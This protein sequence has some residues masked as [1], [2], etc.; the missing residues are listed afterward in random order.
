MRPPKYS[1]YREFTAGTERA[2]RPPG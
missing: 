1:A 2:G